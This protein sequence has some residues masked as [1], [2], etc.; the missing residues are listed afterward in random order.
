MDEVNTIRSSCGTVKLPECC[1][2][3]KK[4]LWTIPFLFLCS[5]A[6]RTLSVCAIR[7]ATLVHDGKYI[8]KLHIDSRRL[9][10][11][12]K[13]WKLPYSASTRKLNWQLMLSDLLQTSI[14]VHTIVSLIIL[15]IDAEL[16]QNWKLSRFIVYTCSY[17]SCTT[18]WRRWSA[19]AL[20]FCSLPCAHRP[21]ICKTTL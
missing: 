16:R 1:K 9:I 18:S 4:R 13:A 21:D 11:E 20:P 17:N 6:C 2:K 3:A 19:T 10:L 7:D 12:R 14:D 8:W 15:K 5:M